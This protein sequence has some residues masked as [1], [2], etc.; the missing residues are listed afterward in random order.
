MRNPDPLN[1]IIAL[2][3]AGFLLLG[4]LLAIAEAH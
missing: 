4:L 3:L 2:T 1:A